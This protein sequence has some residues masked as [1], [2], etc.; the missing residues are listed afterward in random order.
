[1]SRVFNILMSS[2]GLAIRTSKGQSSWSWSSHV[3]RS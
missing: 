2:L 3:A 1:M